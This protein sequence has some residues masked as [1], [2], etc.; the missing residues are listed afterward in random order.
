MAYGGEATCER[1]PDLADE[2]GEKWRVR[3][4]SLLQAGEGQTVDTQ[5]GEQLM[6]SNKRHHL[7]EIQGEQN[8]RIRMH[9][10]PNERTT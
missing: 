10:R 1:K 2:F 3:L 7:E 5:E 8:G 4:E 6:E 9:E